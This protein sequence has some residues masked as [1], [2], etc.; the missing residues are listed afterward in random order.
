MDM[1]IPPLDIKILLES[2]PLKSRIFV[3]H[4]RQ[5]GVGIHAEPASRFSA[6]GH[7]DVVWRGDECRREGADAEMGSP[8]RCRSIVTPTSII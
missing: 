4:T 6:N 7:V 2:N 1:I 8:P 3:R 5:A